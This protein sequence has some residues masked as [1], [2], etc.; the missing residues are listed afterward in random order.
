[1]HLTVGAALCFEPHF[2]LPQSQASTAKTQ[3]NLFDPFLLCGFDAGPGPATVVWYYT[4]AVIR[5]GAPEA[6]INLRLGIS[7]FQQDGVDS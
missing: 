2:S 4:T 5:M 1:M 3:A 6:K 7:N